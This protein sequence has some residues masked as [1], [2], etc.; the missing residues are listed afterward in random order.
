MT[1]RNDTYT[2]KQASLRADL[3]RLRGADH[4]NLSLEDWM[5][6]ALGLIEREKLL[7][8]EEYKERMFEKG[9]GAS[10]IEYREA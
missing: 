4:A 7:V 5:Q 1:Q 3:L 2:K 6:K 9:F 8:L 10:R